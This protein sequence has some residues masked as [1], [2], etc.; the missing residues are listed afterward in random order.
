MSVQPWFYADSD[1]NSSNPA[2][3]KAQEMSTYPLTTKVNLL[4]TIRH[5]QQIDIYT[6]P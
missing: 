3:E 6:E 4:K 1:R 5:A 2:R